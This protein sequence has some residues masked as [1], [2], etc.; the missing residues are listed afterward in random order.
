MNYR[1]VL[2]SGKLTTTGD[3]HIGSGEQ[4]SPETEGGSENL[5]F[6]DDSGQPLIPASTLRGFLRA[7]LRESDQSQALF[8]TARKKI[9]EQQTNLNDYGNIGMLRVYDARLDGPVFKASVVT[10]TRIDPVSG[11]AQQHHLASHQII[12]PGHIFSV[13]LEIDHCGEALIEDQHILDILQA[14]SAFGA[15]PAGHLGQGKSVG[16]GAMSWSLLSLKTLSNDQFIRWLSSGLDDDGKLKQASKPAKKG[17]RCRKQQ[18]GENNQVMASDTRFRQENFKDQTDHFNALLD[19]QATPDQ[20]WDRF[21]FS[22]ISHSPL[23]INDPQRVAK[24]Q[25]EDERRA[26]AEKTATGAPEK[27]TSPDAMN[28]Q[29]DGR[30]R[31]PGSTLK[32]WLRAHCRRIL[33]TLT[34]Q[35]DQAENVEPLLSELFGST[36]TGM[37]WLRFADALSDPVNDEQIHRQTFNAVDRFTGGVKPSALYN[38]EAVYGVAFS[39]ILY[40]RKDQL[41]GWAR[42]LLLYVLRDAM[43]GD[44]TLGWGKTKGYGRL[45]LLQQQIKLERFTPQILSRWQTQLFS[46]PGLEPPA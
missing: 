42:L 23:L 24:T 5:L 28:M 19:S 37:G 17:Q 33:L 22:L 14:L 1:R 4:S 29:R 6:T 15:D 27:T 26:V 8:G 9:D 43:Q 21:E 38:V 39:G 25:A 18:P 20:A 46:Q 16:Q 10:R 2:V 7:Q 40:Y 36:D 3:L 35:P 34:Q 13:N 11:A 32:G 30:A 31:I 45:E 44:L 12:P 41:P